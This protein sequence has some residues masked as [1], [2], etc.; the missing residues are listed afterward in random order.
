[1]NDTTSRSLLKAGY[2]FFIGIAIMAIL[3]ILDLLMG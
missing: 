2:G 3:V 1:M